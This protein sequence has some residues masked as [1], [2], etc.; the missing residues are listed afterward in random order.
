MNGSGST[1]GQ[2][3]R[4]LGTGLRMFIPTAQDTDALAAQVREAGVTL[5]SGP[6]DMPW[7]PSFAITDP[8]GFKLTIARLH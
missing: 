1:E 8:D 6:D 7:G 4:R 2:R 3:G 5:D